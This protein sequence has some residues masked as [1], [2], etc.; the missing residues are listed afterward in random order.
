MNIGSKIRKARLEKQIKQEDLARHLKMGQGTLS[1]I[2]SD[3]LSI[4]VE[5]LLRVAS[6]TEMPINHFL[7][8]GKVVETNHNPSIG[9]FHNQ[10]D[11]DYFQ[12]LH[13]RISDL[14]EWIKDLKS[15]NSEL[16]EKIS[17]RDNDM[18][19]MKREF[20]IYSNYIVHNIN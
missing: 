16:K 6:Y 3:S 17:H 8:E 7:P 9:T 20:E 1:K 12:L 2:E 19:D 4:S 10:S 5:D 11:K 14:E 13:T 18:K 15:L